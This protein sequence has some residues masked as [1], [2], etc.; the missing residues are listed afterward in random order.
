MNTVAV[1]YT[2]SAKV[3]E[4]NSLAFLLEVSTLLLFMY[5]WPG[6]GAMDTSLVHRW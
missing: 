1:E 4:K 5:S 3:G 2:S 6:H